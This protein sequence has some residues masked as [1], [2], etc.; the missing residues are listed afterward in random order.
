MKLGTQGLD[1]MS[2]CFA[3]SLR[4]QRLREI[5]QPY[6]FWGLLGFPPRSVCTVGKFARG[7]LRSANVALTGLSGAA[8]G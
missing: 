1:A 4:K 5:A 2:E 6:R 3:I 8:H 7:K